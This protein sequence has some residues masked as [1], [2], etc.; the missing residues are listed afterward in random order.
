MKSTHLYSDWFKV[1]PVFNNG[2]LNGNYRK[3]SYDDIIYISSSD[4]KNVRK[5]VTNDFVVYDK[6]SLG[7]FA[8]TYKQFVRISK[9]Y[10]LNI[11]FVDKR[12]DWNILWIRELKF[13][14]GRK[15]RDRLKSA[16]EGIL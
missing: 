11:N 5:V 9:S 3:V 6:R 2:L 13:K 16:F 8:S 12:S 15:Y 4:K 10:V 14:V 7:Q 1:N